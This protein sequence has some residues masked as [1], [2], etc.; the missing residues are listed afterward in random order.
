M[1][2]LAGFE[3]VKINSQVVQ[4]SRYLTLR[5]NLVL[6]SNPMSRVVNISHL[7]LLLLALAALGRFIPCVLG[8]LVPG[9]KKLVVCL[10]CS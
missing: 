6:A 5:V 3:L 10:G 1:T 4:L 8:M 2:W 9:A 7:F